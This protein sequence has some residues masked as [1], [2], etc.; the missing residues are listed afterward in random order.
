M[1][2][3]PQLRLRSR[4]HPPGVLTRELLREPVGPGPEISRA[5]NRTVTLQT[6]LCLGLEL[7]K[8][9]KSSHGVILSDFPREMATGVYWCAEKRPF[10]HEGSLH[11]LT[12]RK[13]PLKPEISEVE[14][15]PPCA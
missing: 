12:P 14:D 10:M 5:E 2:L 6:P 15:E 7:R 13:L 4:P 1:T 8:G 3:K 9:L 11:G